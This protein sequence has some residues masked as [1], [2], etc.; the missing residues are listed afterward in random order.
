MSVLIP[1]T[2]DTITDANW[3]L[4]NTTF[5]QVAEGADDILMCIHNI[6]FTM[7][8][9]V[10]FSPFF[11]SDLYLFIDNP[12]NS[13]APYI[14]NE[15]IDAITKWEPRVSVSSVSPTFSDDLSQIVFQVNMIAVSSASPL[16]YTFT[17]N[18]SKNNR[19][20][21]SDGFTTPSFS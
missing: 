20:A 8:G 14:V 11:G 1:V 5:G 4:S 3:Q 17:L 2:I 16:G 7:K 12:V 6:L 9:E 15:I 21:F 10:P 13:V 18:N 19:R